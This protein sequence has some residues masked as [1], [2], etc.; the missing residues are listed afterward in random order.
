MLGHL[1]FLSTSS[2][3]EYLQGARKWLYFCS[4]LLPAT[5]VLCRKS[6]RLLLRNL[7]TSPDDLREWHWPEERDRC[8][9]RGVPCLPGIPR[10]PEPDVVA[11]YP[12]PL[13]RGFVR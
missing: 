8:T 1:W 3:R 5:R 12:R 4:T 11:V 6:K 9:R 2:R 13:P 7:S 10:R